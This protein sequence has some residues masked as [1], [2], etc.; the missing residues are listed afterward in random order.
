[1][2]VARATPRDVKIVQ[3]NEIL[4]VDS[5]QFQALIDAGIRIGTTVTLSDVDGRVIITHG[6]K[7]VELI[8]DLAHAVRIEEI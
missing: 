4:Q 6:E 7:T 2:D 8:D 1:M 5:D 3:I